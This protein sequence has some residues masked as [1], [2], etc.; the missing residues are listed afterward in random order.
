MPLLSSSSAELPIASAPDP[1]PL[2]CPF[3]LKAIVHELLLEEWHHLAHQSLEFR[4]IGSCLDVAQRFKCSQPEILLTTLGQ[5]SSEIHIYH[6]P[7]FLFNWGYSL[8][9]SQWNVSMLCG[10][11]WSGSWNLSNIAGL[12]ASTDLGPRASERPQIDQKHTERKMS[13]SGVAQACDPRTTQTKSGSSPS[14]LSFGQ[15]WATL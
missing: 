13:K 6:N 5:A 14:T 12:L 8:S 9:S 10:T 1:E 7:C 15:A 3:I 11:F 2:L 4:W